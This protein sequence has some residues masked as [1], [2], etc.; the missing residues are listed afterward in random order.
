VIVNFNYAVNYDQNLR[1]ECETYI[2][3]LVAVRYVKGAYMHCW[4]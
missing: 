2:V 1:D 4:S 3:F